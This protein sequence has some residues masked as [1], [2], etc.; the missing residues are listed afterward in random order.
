VSYSVGSGSCFIS[1]GF[2]CDVM[3]TLGLVIGT[4]CF[5]FTLRSTNTVY[6]RLSGLSDITYSVLVQVGGCP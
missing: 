3:S 2:S 6:L 1:G 5:S 4:G